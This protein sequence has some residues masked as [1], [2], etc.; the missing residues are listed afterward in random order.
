[1]TNPEEAILKPGGA[2]LMALY[3]ETVAGTVA[4]RK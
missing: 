1:M 3:N 2:I 4:L